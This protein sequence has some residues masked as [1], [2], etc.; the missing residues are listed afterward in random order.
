MVAVQRRSCRAASRCGSSG[1]RC[2]RRRRMPPPPGMVTAVDSTRAG[3]QACLSLGVVA[4]KGP[5]YWL[6]P[7]PRA[8][9]RPH[10]GGPPASQTP[11]ITPRVNAY[12]KFGVRDRH[13]IEH[14]GAAVAYRCPRTSRTANVQ[15]CGSSLCGEWLCSRR[16]HVVPIG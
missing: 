10:E 15:L 13:I 4:R 9:P 16:E 2:Q 12:C 14:S 7:R 6:S 11:D 5:N 8:R 3:V 1:E